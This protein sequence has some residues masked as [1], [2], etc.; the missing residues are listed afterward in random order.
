MVVLVTGL[1]SVGIGRREVVVLKQ[2]ICFGM[3]P[4]LQ[5]RICR[6]PKWPPALQTL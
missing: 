1:A 5:A 2:V 3:L 6:T 4:S